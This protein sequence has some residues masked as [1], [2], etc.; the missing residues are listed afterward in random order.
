MNKKL[1]ELKNLSFSYGKRKILDGINIDIA[2]KSFTVIAGESG[3]GK[4]TLLYILGGFQRPSSGEYLFGGKRV[5]GKIGEFGLGKF[6][7]NNIGFLFQDFRLLPFLTVEQNI[8]FPAFFSGRKV[9]KTQMLKRMQK[10]G[11]DHRAKAYPTQISGGEAQ[12]T[13]LARAL[14]MNPP[15]LL[16]DEPTGNL[17]HTT[18]LAI[19]SLLEE[20]RGEGLTLVCV[21]HSDYIMSRADVTLRLHDGHLDFDKKKVARRGRK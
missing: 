17:D 7:K 15:V 20:L 12:R 10:L 2:Q 8:R 9:D 18:E 1:I 16:L 4:S 6:R 21:S 3:S 19:V 13:A 14:W 5:Y 11:I